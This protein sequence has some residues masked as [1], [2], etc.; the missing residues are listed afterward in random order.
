MGRNAKMRKAQIEEIFDESHKLIGEGL[1]SVI[2]ASLRVY[3]LKEA[4]G[5]LKSE[6]LSHLGQDPFEG[7]SNHVKP[8]DST[9]PSASNDSPA[10]Q[11]EENNHRDKTQT[12]L[13]QRTDDLPKKGKSGFSY[14]RSHPRFPS[15]RPTSRPKGLN[16]TPAQTQRDLRRRMAPTTTDNSKSN[17]KVASKSTFRK[18]TDSPSKPG[19][20]FRGGWISTSHS[21][22]KK[23]PRSPQAKDFLFNV[24]KKI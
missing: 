1:V 18:K 14:G 12:T 8:S 4:F 17:A 5:E 22:D 3:G 21:Q 13:P 16:R 23:A 11:R 19:E 15:S 24:V 20:V 9:N 7:G 10:N 2:D 6:S